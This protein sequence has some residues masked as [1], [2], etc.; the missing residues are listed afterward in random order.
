MRWNFFYALILSL[1]ALTINLLAVGFLLRSKNL[2]KSRFNTLVLYLSISD[3]C[4]L[5]QII[6]HTFFEH[7]FEDT[8]AGLYGCMG[9][10]HSIG[11]T[12]CFTEWQMA[13]ICMERLQATFQHEIP[14][15]KKLTS[16]RSLGISFVASQLYS[17]VPLAYE[18]SQG[19]QPCHASYTL[20]PSLKYSIDIPLFCTYWALVTLYGVIIYRMVK[21]IRKWTTELETGHTLTR[22]RLNNIKRMKMN[23]VTLGII[24]AVTTLA[25]LPREICAIVSTFV[26]HNE[27]LQKFIQFGNYVLLLNPLIDPFIYVLRIEEVRKKVSCCS[28]TT[29]VEP[30]HIKV[31]PQNNENGASTSGQAVSS[32]PFRSFN[33]SSK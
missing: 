25:V 1:I 7:V 32:V 28:K 2:K 18:I 12:V 4:L 9:M 26:A 23:M 24:L 11:G 15:L 27:F 30:I 29:R 20:R 22:N 5:V 21:I 33:N 14:I 3:C 10:K 6:L 13:M 31:Q 19:P 17:F 8:A 16:A